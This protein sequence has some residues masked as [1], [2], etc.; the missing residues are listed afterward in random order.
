VLRG[1]I[2]VVEQLRPEVITMKA[3]WGA[4]IGTFKVDKIFVEDI[5]LR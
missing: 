3:G 1:I 4:I 5:R 2:D